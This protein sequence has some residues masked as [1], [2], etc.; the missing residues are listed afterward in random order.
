TVGTLRPTAPEAVS[1]LALPAPATAARFRVLQ[2]AG[3]GPAGRPHLMWVRELELFG[4]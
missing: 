3:K 1:T 2:P 4:E